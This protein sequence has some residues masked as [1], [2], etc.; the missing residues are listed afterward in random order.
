MSFLFGKP[1]TSAQVAAIEAQNKQ[2]EL[3][4]TQIEKQELRQRQEESEK[5]KRMQAAARAR[6]RGGSRSLVSDEREDALTGIV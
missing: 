4:R 3:Q 2:L 1:D 5:A 6:M